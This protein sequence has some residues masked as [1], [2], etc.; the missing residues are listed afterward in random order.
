MHLFFIIFPYFLIFSRSKC[1]NEIKKIKV[2]VKRRKHTDRKIAKTT[3]SGLG[4][5]YV[6]HCTA[7]ASWAQIRLLFQPI[8]S[9]G[10]YSPSWAAPT[11]STLLF[12]HQQWLFSEAGLGPSVSVTYAG[13][14]VSGKQEAVN[15]SGSAHLISIPPPHR[16]LRA[17]FF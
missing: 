1:D 17:I 3:A 9:S 14:M 2:I 8:K 5:Q 13:K 16:L 11:K 15:F 7:I 4:P 6:E 12:S 10:S